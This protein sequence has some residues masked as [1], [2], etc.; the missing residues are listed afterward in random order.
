M[1][2][3]VTTHSLQ[4]PN[5]GSYFAG[6]QVT[7]QDGKKR[8]RIHLGQFQFRQSREIIDESMERGDKWINLPLKIWWSIVTKSGC[9]QQILMPLITNKLDA[10]YKGW[11]NMSLFTLYF[12]KSGY[13]KQLSNIF[14]KK[15]KSLGLNNS[16]FF[17]CHHINNLLKV[18]I[19][20]YKTDSGLKTISMLQYI[21]DVKRGKQQT[22]LV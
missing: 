12:F 10:N 22:T 17:V 20:V 19:G 14:N 1:L 3:H 2:A 7:K 18:F 15:K 11:A 6:V 21:R 8:N 4:A 9:S 13:N 16:D 5:W